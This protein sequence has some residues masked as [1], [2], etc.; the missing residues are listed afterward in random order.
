MPLQPVASG[1]TTANT[2]SDHE[3]LPNNEEQVTE[4]S[5]DDGKSIANF[6]ILFH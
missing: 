4:F 3:N 1:L 6:G 2:T 5:S